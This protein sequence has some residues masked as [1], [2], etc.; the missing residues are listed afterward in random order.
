MH[1]IIAGYKNN[2]YYICAFPNQLPYTK[3]IKSIYEK[4][5]P[6]AKFEVL[7]GSMGRITHSRFKSCL[8]F[9]KAYMANEHLV[10]TIG[11]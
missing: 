1:H 7:E 2:D 11:E 9:V 3:T 5:F 10:E 4:Q 8:E 6:N